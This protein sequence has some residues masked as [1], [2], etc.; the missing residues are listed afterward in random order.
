MMNT[1]FAN[2][3]P[4]TSPE[5]KCDM[6]RDCTDTVTHIDN[7]GWVYCSRHGAQRRGG[8]IRCR[9]LTAL[10]AQDLRDGNP[11]AYARNR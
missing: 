11:I 8:G 7:K 10:E 9:R 2:H 6:S 3:K 5:L 4:L 1:Q